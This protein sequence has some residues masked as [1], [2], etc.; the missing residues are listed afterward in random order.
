M[1]LQ[2]TKRLC[3]RLILIVVML[4]GI[5]GVVFS[6]A[7]AERATEPSVLEKECDPGTGWMWTMGPGEPAVA[8]QVQQELSQK[9][10]QAMVEARNYGE[11]DSCGTY[12]SEGID[13]TIRLQAAK[14]A[15]PDLVDTI[16]PIVTRFGKPRLGNVKL[17]S[18][19]G[20]LISTDFQKGLPASRD[21]EIEFSTAE[22]L[23]GDPMTRKVYVIV[24]DPLLSSGQKLSQHLGWN[25]HATITQQT[26]DFFKQAPTTK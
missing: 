21:M 16:A 13:F 23:P 22:P 4:M 25:S 3:S 2:K 5:S 20:H 1:A 19:E 6:R 17:F 26:V 12:H 18:A 24:Y 14:S 7:R 15:Q 9:G 8:T 11:V 10:I